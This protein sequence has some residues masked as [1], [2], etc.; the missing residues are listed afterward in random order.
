[1]V[2]RRA[3]LSTTPGEYGLFAGGSGTP[4]AYIC[5]GNSY[6]TRLGVGGTTGIL[7]LNTLHHLVM[8]WNGGTTFSSVRFYVDGKLDSSNDLDSFGA[9]SS[10]KNASIPLTIGGMTDGSYTS[11]MIFDVCAYNRILTEPEIRLLASRPGIG[12][13]PSPTR[14][15]ARQKQTGLR[16]KILTGQT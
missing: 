10:I 15:I 13:Q 11:G 14:F 12:L 2:A 3:D 16:R 5:D 1:M 4:F 7:K 6:Q 8:T 9:F